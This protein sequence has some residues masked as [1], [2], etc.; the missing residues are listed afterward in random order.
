MRIKYRLSYLLRVFL[1]KGWRRGVYHLRA[2]R[3][4]PF[5]PHRYSGFTIFRLRS[6][7]SPVGAGLRGKRRWKN[8]SPGEGLG[9]QLA[10]GLCQ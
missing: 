6:V 9:T 3:L 5:S 8:R 1:R 7:H 2:C 10:A 4:I